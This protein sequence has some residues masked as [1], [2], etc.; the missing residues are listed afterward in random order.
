MVHPGDD[1]TDHL[2]RIQIAL[3]RRPAEEITSIIRDRW[4]LQSVVIDVLRLLQTTSPCAVVEL[5]SPTTQNVPAL[6]KAVELASVKASELDVDESRIVDSMLRGDSGGRGPFSRLGWIEEVRL[7]IQRSVPS[8]HIEFDGTIQQLNGGSSFALMRLGTLSPPA[9]W[10]KAAGS[11]NLHELRI[12]TAI[13]E[14][15]PDYLPPLIASRMDWNA[16][17]SEES[18]RP[19]GQ[20]ASAVAYERA[21]AAVAELQIKSRSNITSLMHAGC[22]D[23]RVIVLYHKAAQLID[24]LKDAMT[25]QTSTKATR[26]EESQIDALET[27]IR[28]ACAKMLDLYIPDTLIHNDLNAGNILVSDE[29]CVFTDWAEGCIGNPFAT[30]Q[31]LCLQAT[32]QS[33]NAVT[34]LPSLKT[35]FKATWHHVLSERTIDSAFKLA[36]L[37]AIVS[38]LYGRGDWFDTPASRLPT[39]QGHARAL[40]RHLNK[41]VQILQQDITH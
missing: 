22:A 18:G 39:F 5:L 6:W 38:Y 1:G 37:L 30:L 8:R 11:P 19:I 26:L 31:H 36:P 27:A 3:G 29:R 13:A 24:Y 40:T 15:A 9:Y 2:P 17:I 23:Q 12:T 33:N 4:K 21:S 28:T 32:K 7:W 34:W 35:T 14:F 10:L 41:A 20:C 16:W 25:K